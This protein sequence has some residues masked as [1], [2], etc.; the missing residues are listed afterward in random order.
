M[1]I[2]KRDLGVKVLTKRDIYIKGDILRKI[3]LYDFNK[4]F[5]DFVFKFKLLFSMHS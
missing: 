3:F 1:L 4:V 2:C 5:I